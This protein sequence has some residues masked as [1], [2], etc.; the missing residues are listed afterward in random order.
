MATSTTEAEYVAVAHCCGQVLWIQNQMLDYGFNFMNTQIF[1][2]NESTISI[3]KNPVYHSKTKHIEIRHHFIRD[4]YEKKLIQVL[5]IHTDDNV[6]NLLTKAFDGPRFNFFVTNF[7]RKSMDL[8]LDGSCDD[9]DLSHIWLYLSL[10]VKVDFLKRN[11][12]CM[13]GPQYQYLIDSLVNRSEQTDTSI[14][15]ANG[16]QEL[17]ATI[18]G[19]AYTIT[20]AS[21]RSSLQLAYATGITNLP[22]AEI[23]EGLATMS[24]EVD[25]E[26]AATTTA[27]LEAGL[28]SGNIHESSFVSHDLHSLPEVV[29]LESE[30][31]EAENSFK[32]GRKSQDD[33]SKDFITPLKVNAL[34]EAQEQDINPT[35]LDA[36]KTLTQVASRGVHTYKRRRRSIDSISSRKG[37]AKMVEEDVQTVQKTKKQLEQE[38]AGFAEGIRLQAQLDAEVAEQIYTYEMIAKRMEEETEMNDNRIK[39]AQVKICLK[40]IL[41]KDGRMENRGERNILQKKELRQRE[42]TWKLSQLKKLTFEE[43]KE[44]FDKDFKGTNDV[45][46]SGSAEL[47]GKVTQM[48]LIHKIPKER[49]WTGWL[50][51]GTRGREFSIERDM[52]G[53]SIDKK[54]K[55]TAGLFVGKALTWWN[56]QIHTLSREIAV[57]MSWNDF[58]FIMIEEFYPSH[59]MQ[60]PIRRIHQGRYGVSVPA[61]TKDHKG[62]KLNTPYPEDQ[63]AVLRNEYNIL[64]DIKRGPYSKKPPIR[65]DLDNS[66]SNVLIPLDSWTSGLLVYKLP[67][68]DCIGLDN[69][70]VTMEEYIRLEKEKARKC[71]KVFNWQTATYGKIR[72]DDDLHDLSSVEAE[73]PTIV[74]NDDFAPQDTLQC[75]SQV[76]TPVNDEIDFRISFD[77]SD[78][79]D[80][81]RIYEK[82]LFSYKMISVNNLK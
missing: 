13:L 58:K 23:H 31:E 56:S 43:I 1:I 52:S 51:R 26:G 21:V 71:G 10:S 53:C 65:R 9:D 14:T 17:L 75:K 3:V 45:D 47:L 29:L 42:V 62:I 59:E 50:V 41:Q 77:E 27:S 60:K 80:Y 8:K 28:D 16:N 34:G 82:N 44:K 2:D 30:R 25:A 36:A 22:D 19:K 76:S 72:I 81:T 69:Q 18:D 63:Y 57:I 73:F 78:D 4:S 66:T 55:Y 48:T 37:K 79:E 35:L 38:K 67:L 11:P 74:I 40:K 68:S 6:A 70:N 12:L 7:F 15:L 32:Q 5:K 64:K 20:K 46:D 61:L 24:V 33:R 49:P 39:N 54:V